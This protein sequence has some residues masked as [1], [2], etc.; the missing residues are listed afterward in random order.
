MV[1]RGTFHFAQNRNFSCCLDSPAFVKT[2]S[3]AKASVCDKSTPD[4][5]A[6]NLRQ[7]KKIKNHL[8]KW[9]GQP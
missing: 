4:A 7:I 2:S 3:I 5:M 8:K 1:K 6:D 9:Q